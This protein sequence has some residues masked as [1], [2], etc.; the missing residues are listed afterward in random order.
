MGAVG[1]P[2]DGI[3][4]SE[5]GEWA[6]AGESSG[7]LTQAGLCAV[8]PPD[9][10]GAQSSVGGGQACPNPVESSPEI[11]RVEAAAQQRQCAL[12]PGEADAKLLVEPVRQFGDIATAHG[13]ACGESGE[14]GPSAKHVH[15]TAQRLHAAH[16]R[17][18][19]SVA[20]AVDAVAELIARRDDDLGGG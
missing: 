16:H 5:H 17:G 12:A 18:I 8:V 7:A 19:E 3:T 1:V 4:A 10:G 15:A 20:H 11:E 9:D 14:G 2:G 6:E 13:Q